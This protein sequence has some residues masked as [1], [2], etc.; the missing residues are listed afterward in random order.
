MF[1]LIKLAA[2]ALFGYALYEF[3]RGISQDR[4]QSDSEGQGGGGRQLRE[5]LN[6]D[7]SRNPSLTGEGRGTAVATQDA[8]GGSARHVVGRG[9]VH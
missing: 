4:G 5:A 2:Y 8:S 7:S 9:V 1:R 6:Q 3:F